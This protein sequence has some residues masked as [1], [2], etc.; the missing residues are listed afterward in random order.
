[1]DPHDNDAD[2]DNDTT[3]GWIIVRSELTPSRTKNNRRKN[4]ESIG[5]CDGMGGQGQYPVINNKWT[6]QLSLFSRV[7]ATL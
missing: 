6:A 1:M 5:V 3:G 2:D 7:Y 4:L